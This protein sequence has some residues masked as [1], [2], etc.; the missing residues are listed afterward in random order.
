[1]ASDRDNDAVVA[2]DDEVRGDAEY[3]VGD[4]GV[5]GDAD[6]GGVGVRNDDI[7]PH[8][9]GDASGVA[10]GDDEVLDVAPVG[11]IGGDEVGGDAGRGSVRDSGYGWRNAG[12]VDDGS[13]TCAGTVSWAS[14]G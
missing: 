3:G 14:V 13:L 11:V 6:A 1:M 4:D 5:D 8:P 10:V 12:A 9:D 2:G 7:D